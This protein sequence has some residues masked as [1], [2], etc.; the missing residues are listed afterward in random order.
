MDRSNYHSHIIMPF[1]RDYY[2]WPDNMADRYSR[3][4]HE[5]HQLICTTDSGVLMDMRAAMPNVFDMAIT[6]SYV[7]PYVAELT[8]DWV[9]NLGFEPVQTIVWKNA[10]QAWLNDL[11]DYAELRKNRDP[12]FRTYDSEVW[13]EFFDEFKNTPGKHRNE[14]IVTSDGVLIAEA[15]E[16]QAVLEATLSET[17][18]FPTVSPE[19]EH[20]LG[21]VNG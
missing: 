2:I 7:N 10:R 16:A 18:E 21:E 1:L 9:D 3:A 4:M 13:A 15:N 8:E 5:A 19:K 17:A 11:L 12:K 6:Y 14:F 20:A